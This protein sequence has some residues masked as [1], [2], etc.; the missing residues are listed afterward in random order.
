MVGGGVSQALQV[1]ALSPGL[2]HQLVL[3]MTSGEIIDRGPRD[4]ETWE[5]LSPHWALHGDQW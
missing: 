1:Q 4:A 5:L 3:A 2:L